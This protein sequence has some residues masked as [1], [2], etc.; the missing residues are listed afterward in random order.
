MLPPQQSWAVSDTVQ[1]LLSFI[2]PACDPESG[3]AIWGT[4]IRKL[5]HF[6]EFTVLG[7]LLSLRFDERSAKVYP[8]ILFGILTA[9]MDETIQHFTDRTSSVFDVWLDTLGVNVG[10]LLQLGIQHVKQFY[11]ER[12]AAERG[13]KCGEE[14]VKNEI[15]KEV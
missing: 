5:A 2:S 10:F 13:T 1:Q 8:V 15:T 11:T 4:V 12:R 14:R 9:L 6:T 3:I 7:F